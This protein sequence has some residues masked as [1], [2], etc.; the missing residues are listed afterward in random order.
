MAEPWEQGRDVEGQ[1]LH[2]SFHCRDA[3][4]VPANHFCVLLMSELKWL[5]AV[6]EGFQEEARLEP[7]LVCRVDWEKEKTFQASLRNNEEANWNEVTI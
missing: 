5:V 7:R 3:D 1:F 6:R 4:S 2:G